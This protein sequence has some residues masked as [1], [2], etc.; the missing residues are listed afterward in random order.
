[1][2]DDALP[3]TQRHAAWRSGTSTVATS[4]ADFVSGSGWG[5]LDG[6]LA[7]ATLKGT[8]LRLLTFDSSRRLVRQ[9][10]P[11]ELSGTYGRLRGVQRGPGGVLYVTTS[12]GT[13]DKI[14][15]VAP[16]G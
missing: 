14:L 16:R 7:V 11:S 8:S 6:A 1:M 15:R 10:T 2:T 13:D 3:G 4:G 9:Y 12:N 5:S